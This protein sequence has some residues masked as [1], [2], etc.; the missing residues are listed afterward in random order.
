VHRLDFV[1]RK[2]LF[3]TLTLIAVLIFN[4]FLFRI[5]PGDPVQMIVSPRMRPETRER[6]REQYGLDKPI[7]IN[8]AQFGETGNFSDLFDSQFVRYVD[9]LLHGNLGESFRQKKPVAELIGN[10]HRPYSALDPRRRNY[11]DR[12]WFRPGY[13]RSMEKGDCY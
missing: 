4:F 8:S 7:W 3:S 6:I 5:I 9:N 1:V 10:P 13:H 11:W 12:L 2:G